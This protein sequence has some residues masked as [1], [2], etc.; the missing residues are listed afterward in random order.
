MDVGWAKESCEEKK[1]QQKEQKQPISFYKP[2]QLYRT[3]QK[4]HSR[5]MDM[6]DLLHA[7]LQGLAS[8]RFERFERK[9]AY[10]NKM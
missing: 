8:H 6:Y 3:S 1:I 5:Q 2:Q 10:E 4:E 7:T 9:M